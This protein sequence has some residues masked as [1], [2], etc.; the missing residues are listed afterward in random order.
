MQADG[1]EVLVSSDE[2]EEGGVADFAEGRQAGIQLGTHGQLDC[3]LGRDRRGSRC[4]VL[5]ELGDEHAAR[6]VALLAPVV[7]HAL[8]LDG[9]EEELEELVLD[10]VDELRRDDVAGG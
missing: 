7:R 8:A 9:F 3:L 4:H 2:V 1:V 10:L 5:D 6:V